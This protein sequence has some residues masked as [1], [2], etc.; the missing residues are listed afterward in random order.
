[1]AVTALRGE[2]D[3]VSFEGEFLH[4]AEVRQLA[5]EVKVSASADLDCH[6]PKYWPGR[7]TVKLTD[8]QSHSEEVIIPKG[9]S[10]NPM[11]A[12]EV[13]EKFLSLATAVLG[14]VKAKA[15]AREAQSLEDRELLESLLGM[16]K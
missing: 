7:V 6:Y 11:T 8:G 1:M 2:I 4:S 15:V 5:S 12:R 10:G 3:L 9:E 16:L 14:D 13:E